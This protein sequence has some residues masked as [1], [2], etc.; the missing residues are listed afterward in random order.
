[1]TLA[2]IGIWT[3]VSAVIGLIM[4]IIEFLVWDKLRKKKLR[5]LFERNTL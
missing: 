5:K 4:V 1:M 2:T 3:G